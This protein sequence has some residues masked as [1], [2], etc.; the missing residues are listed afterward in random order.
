[1]VSGLSYGAYSPSISMRDRMYA[2]ECRRRAQE[3]LKEEMKS[4]PSV[5]CGG[6]TMKVKPE[7]LNELIA[8]G[9]VAE[10]NGMY[11]EI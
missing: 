9:M 2:N 5:S 3:A 6:N 1:M 8:A 4:W 7:E 11:F 10:L